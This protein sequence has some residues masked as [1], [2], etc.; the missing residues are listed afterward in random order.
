MISSFRPYWQILACYGKNQMLLLLSGLLLILTLPFGIPIVIRSLSPFV[1]M[2]WLLYWGFVLYTQFTHPRAVLFPGFR[3][4][5]LWVALG[6]FSFYSVFML[7]LFQ[8][9]QYLD[10]FNAIQKLIIILLGS[11]LLLWDMYMRS[12]I[13]ILPLSFIPMIDLLWKDSSLIHRI[14]IIS[15]F[16]LKPEFLIF[17]IAVILLLLCSL[18]WKLWTLREESWEYHTGMYGTLFSKLDPL[19]KQGL[20][21]L[22]S[23]ENQRKVLAYPASNG[24]FKRI[25]YWSIISNG[26]R[27]TTFQFLLMTLVTLAVI[28]FCLSLYDWDIFK[29]FEKMDFSDIAL[30]NTTLI[31]PLIIT[32]TYMRNSVLKSSN[33]VLKPICRKRLILEIALAESFLSVLPFFFIGIYLFVIPTFILKPALLLTPNCWVTIAILYSSALFMTSLGR[34]TIGFLNDKIFRFISFFYILILF[35]PLIRIIPSNFHTFHLSTAHSFFIS[36]GLLTAAAV[37][38]RLGYELA[39]RAEIG[40]K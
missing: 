17:H 13:L 4:K 2:F 21:T 27:S 3:L 24:L 29:M 32:I 14:F 37:L 15:D 26:G 25:Q 22:H 28:I 6:S 9:Y 40:E 8:S 20:N 7:Y 30:S 11:L 38:W 5:N 34:M 18:G 10:N 1:G 33:V 19:K 16:L 35:T 12:M 31:M 23:K 36:F 39:C